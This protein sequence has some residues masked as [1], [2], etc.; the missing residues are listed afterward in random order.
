MRNETCLLLK[1]TQQCFPFVLV[2]ALASLCLHVYLFSFYT[3]SPPRQ[4][5][6]GVTTDPDECRGS[7]QCQHSPA[8]FSYYGAASWRVANSNSDR[9]YTSPMRERFSGELA[10]RTHVGFV[11]PEDIAKGFSRDNSHLQSSAGLAAAEE[12]QSSAA[13]RS[14]AGPGGAGMGADPPRDGDMGGLID[15]GVGHA[16]TQ[17]GRKQSNRRRLQTCPSY[18]DGDVVAMRLDA[19]KGTMLMSL[20]DVPQCWYTAMPAESVYHV[21]VS[22]DKE[23]DHVE[24]L[25]TRYV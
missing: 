5:W 2:A 23:G 1:T 20:N 25:P 19:A 8:T 9:G 11:A 10:E 22:I 3:R 13:V 24:L 16:V 12:E 7:S 4:M 15:E 14:G 17:L 18:Q 21:W 6:I